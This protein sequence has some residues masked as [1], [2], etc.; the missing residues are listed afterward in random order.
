LPRRGAEIE[1][2]AKRFPDLP[3]IIESRG[4]LAF[5][6]GQ[7]DSA[8]AQYALLETSPNI[9]YRANGWGWSG[10]LLYMQGRTAEGWRAFERAR[11]LD[12][13]RGVRSFRLEDSLTVAEA[14]ALLRD[15]PAE[16]VKRIDAALVRD[17]LES[18]ALNGRSYF[19]M[20]RVLAQAGRHDAPTQCSHDMTR[21]FAT[22]YGGGLIAR[23]GRTPRL[24]IDLTAGRP[25]TMPSRSFVSPRCFLMVRERG[26]RSVST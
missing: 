11:A 8:A 15:N 1:A 12:S 10:L 4:D 21:M 2:A 16:A 9:Q 22:L 5:A 18:V 23:T 17:P 7:L 20:V 26:A 24:W 6:K 13:T 19:Q 25:A 14:Y 3:R